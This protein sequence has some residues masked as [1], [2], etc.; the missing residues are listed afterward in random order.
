VRRS[1][2]DRLLAAFGVLNAHGI[3]A[4]GACSTDPAAVRAALASSIRQRNPAAAGSYVFWTSS[5]E[6]CFTEDGS[7]RGTLTLFASGPAV[8]RAVMAALAQQGLCAVTASDG[9]IGVL[10]TAAD[11]PSLN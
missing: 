9:S 4:L 8:A 5:D 10:P 11:E 7:L 2:R 1:A 3:V 6:E